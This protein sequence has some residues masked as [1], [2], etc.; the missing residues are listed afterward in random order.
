MDNSNSFFVLLVTI[1]FN[2]LSE[3]IE[4]IEQLMVI[5]KPNCF[6][7]RSKGCHD[8]MIVKYALGMLIIYK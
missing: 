7:V 3:Q 4:I 6:L 8:I 5:A 1:D 2:A